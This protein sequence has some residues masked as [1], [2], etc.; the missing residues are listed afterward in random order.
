MIIPGRVLIAPG[1]KHL[2]INGNMRVLK[3]NIIDAEPVN[4]HRPSVDVMFD[5]VAAI[6]KNK[7]T[8]VLLTGMGPMVPRLTEHEKCRCSYFGSG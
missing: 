8:G 4:R 3:A 1:N 5:S 2:V 7:A 6:A